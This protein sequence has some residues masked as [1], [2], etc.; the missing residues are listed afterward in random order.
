MTKQIK[1]LDNINT[2]TVLFSF[3]NHM[4]FYSMHKSQVYAIILLS[5]FTPAQEQCAHCL[6]EQ[7]QI[8]P[9]LDT[10]TGHHRKSKLCL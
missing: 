3:N 8:H 4:H 9:S 1:N 10:E 6:Q 5:S 7:Q 2:I